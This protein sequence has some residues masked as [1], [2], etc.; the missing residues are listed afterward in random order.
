[1]E[2][3]VE[4]ENQVLRL[5][6]RVEYLEYMLDKSGICYESDGDNQINNGMES[7]DTDQ[8]AR[9]IHQTIT[10]EHLQLFYRMFKGR[11]DVYSRRGGKP[12][13]KTGRT[14]YFTQCF[15]SFNYSICPKRRG[16]G[17]SCGKCDFQS[18]KPLRGR[19]LLAH[20]T[21]EREDCGD[22]IGIYPMLLDETCNFLVFDFDNHDANNTLDDGANP[23]NSWVEEVNAMRT[24]CRENDVDVLVER[25]RSGKGAHVWLFFEESVKVSLA[26]RFGDALLTKGA[27]SVN[28][29]NFKSYDRMIPAQ[30]R[31]PEGGLGNLIAL[32]LQGRALLKGN[33]AFIDE[34][35]NAY[36]DQ[37]K[38]LSEV[39]K[40]SRQFIENAIKEWGDDGT[41][42][43]LAED[44]SESTGDE[45][46][47][48]PWEKKK[49]FNA[50]DVAGKVDITIADRIYIYKGNIKIRMQNQLRRLAAFSNSEFYKMQAMGHYVGGLSRIISCSEDEGGYILLP[51]GCEESLVRN[52]QEADIDFDISDRR[53]DG[54]SINVSFKGELYPEQ[55]K[56]ADRMLEYDNGVLHAATAFGKTAV[57]AYMISAHKVNTLI[58]VHNNEIL[59]NWVDDLDKFLDI[60]EEPPEYTTPSG[61]TKKRKSVI[62]RLTSSHNSVTGIID[63]VM[64]SS[65]GKK[66]D[67][68]EM[69]KK[70]GQVIMDECHHAA[71]QTAYNVLNEVNARYVYGLTATPKR[72][73]GQ[74][75]KIFMLLGPIRYRYT[76]RDRADMQGIPHY[77]YP[78]FTRLIHP[79]EDKLS[80]AEANRL[81]VESETRNNQ[82]IDDAEECIKN[83][84]SPLV[85]TK[86]RE[87][88]EYLYN[89]LQY[90]ADNVFL[91]MGGRSSKERDDIRT[92]MMMVPEDETVI[93][94]AT[95]Q[96]IGEGFNYPRLD[97]MLLT[98]PISY[99]G[100]V[101][102][103]SGRLHRD[104]APKSD[105]IIYDYVDSHIS[106]LERMYRKRLRTYKK[107]GYEICLGVKAEKQTANAIYG[108]ENY[109]PVY[110]CDL[111]EAA[112]EIIIS[113][114][115]IN[116]EK[117][118]DIIGMLK[119]I[120]ESGVKVTVLTL[121]PDIYPEARVEI[122][123]SLI[124]E[125]KNAG[126]AIKLKDIMHE[127]YA[128]IDREIV[129]YGSLNFLSREREEDNLMR[130]RSKDIAT[131]LLE[132]EFGA[133][134]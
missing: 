113:S 107:M 112:E 58:L 83:G 78:R 91:L 24:I 97:T 98:M 39:R 52:L 19:D 34:A 89:R 38:K 6:A 12:S 31:L 57:G 61:R 90:S 101:E 67:I 32:P 20:L 84:R 23:D 123:H 51:R 118:K 7:Q 21:G 124:Q 22:V 28:Q 117:V 115:G 40:I 133:K 2:K 130:V 81:I 18:Y 66:D 87:H 59:K 29:K 99:E 37:W 8:G 96:Y 121:N 36:P 131:E 15:N 70:Y 132:M 48:K 103:Y 1:M 93:L 64:I 62:G 76:A 65:L 69:V 42:G 4:L 73:D 53:N 44:I 35:W 55:Q 25:S 5:K 77:V 106:K 134:K 110:R 13:P 129:W 119:P 16:I 46:A 114:P 79:E 54:N 126:I 17:I 128:V 105:V 102:Q 71:S 49:R 30:D 85:I 47:E 27:Q 11:T 86:N 116:K 45:S 26:R 74:D 3:V 41:L 80:I 56:A 125:L 95:G 10:N 92:Q 94:V 109:M 60:D 43:F 108:I 122:T 120:Q 50:E 82:I 14:G 104:Y 9:I 100:N 68:N 63:V 33:S 111:R 88:A 75:K 127:H 72:D